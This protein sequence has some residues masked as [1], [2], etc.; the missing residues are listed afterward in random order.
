VKSALNSEFNLDGKR[1]VI[2][3]A[4]G[5]AYK[6]APMIL[7]ELGADTIVRGE[8]P[9]GTNINELC[10]ALY[11]EKTAQ[12]VLKYR[13]D[14]GICLDGDADRLILSDE[15]G[16][17]VNGDVILGILSKFLLDTGHI[18]NGDEVVGTILS[19]LGLEN[20]LQKIGLKFYRENV[21]DRYIVN[22]MLKVSS[23]IGG[24]SSGHI[25]LREFATTGD[26]L[27]SALKVLEAMD[28]YDKPLSELAEQVVLYPQVMENLTVQQKT[29]LEELSGLQRKIETIEKS[30]QG[31]GRIILR[32]SGTEP[33][34]RIMVEA[35][36]ESIA[37]TV[38]DE[39][40]TFLQ[41]ALAE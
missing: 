12:R 21:G 28:Y 39:M 4:N 11:P 3:C 1:V 20:Y 40:K 17:V 15:K 33:L 8:R 32:Y 30:L 29:P 24:E 9:N 25:I 37:Q 35:V 13:G 41:Q 10:G 16:Q 19:N 18:N 5:A 26:G 6:I 23:L 31:K 7:T 36:E 14:I 2:D 34:L 27:V 22:R 38:V